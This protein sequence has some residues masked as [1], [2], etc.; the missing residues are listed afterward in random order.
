MATGQI[1]KKN[2]EDELIDLDQNF[3]ADAIN[4]ELDKIFKGK[5]VELTS[6]DRSLAVKFFEKHIKTLTPA[7]NDYLG[8]IESARAMNFINTFNEYENKTGFNIVSGFDMDK[9]IEHYKTMPKIFN[10][11]QQIDY[12][13]IFHSDGSQGKE[14]FKAM[15]DFKDN[16]SGM[17][18]LRPNGSAVLKDF[19]FDGRG[20]LD[21]IIKD[22]KIGVVGPGMNSFQVDDLTRKGMK[23]G[24][25]VMEIN[26]ENLLKIRN[27]IKNFNFNLDS[28]RQI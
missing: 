8:K 23:N 22:G 14:S 11:E 16:T 27:F 10:G 13:K 3:S 21:I 20:K 24:E 17:I 1:V 26:N 19:S 9:F 25:P 5:Q 18:E 6:Q 15:L 28:T 2:E 7:A 4:N 12:L